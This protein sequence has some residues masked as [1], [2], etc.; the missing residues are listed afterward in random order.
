MLLNVGVLD[1]KVA[2][3]AGIMMAI[4]APIFDMI[5]GATRME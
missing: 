3:L 1:K 4:D 2:H 5:N